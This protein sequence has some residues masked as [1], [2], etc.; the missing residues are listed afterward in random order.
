MASHLPHRRA[1]TLT[2]V[3]LSTLHTTKSTMA[4]NHDHDWDENRILRRHTVDTENPRHA[5]HAQI[6]PVSPASAPVPD[7]L[8]LPP[9]ALLYNY[10]S[11]PLYV[12]S[13]PRGKRSSDTYPDDLR[14]TLSTLVNLKLD[15][16]VLE[17]DLVGKRRHSCQARKLHKTSPTSRDLRATKRRIRQY[18]QR[19][20]AKSQRK[21]IYKLWSQCS[22][23][24]THQ[25]KKT[26]K[27][28]VP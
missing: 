4:Q 16:T 26:S 24:V 19:K 18:R 28:A 25:N 17:T 13:V 1:S 2:T 14:A 22:A 20:L 12:L 5:L 11:C 6:S 7:L 9:S 3:H 8:E 15:E 10:Q 23:I 27:L 21:E